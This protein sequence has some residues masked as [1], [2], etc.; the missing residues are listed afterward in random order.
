MLYS[1]ADDPATLSHA[2]ESTFVTDAAPILLPEVR[3]NALLAEQGLLWLSAAESCS[4]GEIAHR[5]TAVAG[6]STY[7]RGSIVAYANEAKR[8]LLGVPAD[9]LANPG[10]V[11]ELCARA[12]AEGSRAAFDSDIAV[13]TTGIAG[14]AG[15]TERKPVGLVYIAVAGP[16]G[17]ECA[18]HHFP[19]DRRAVVDAAADTGLHDLLAYVERVLAARAG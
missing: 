7:V 2:P 9:V 17:V 3:L 19:G 10:A 14:P 12:M 16:L 4:G 18:E 11:S 8:D 6:S 15:G 5:L 1:N 13:A